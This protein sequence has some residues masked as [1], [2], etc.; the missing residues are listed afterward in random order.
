[1]KHSRIGPALMLAIPIVLSGCIPITF[2]CGGPEYRFASALARITDATDTLHADVYVGAS[3]QRGGGQ[4]T[5]NSFSVNVQAVP[6]Q[7]TVLPLPGLFGH[8]TS[9]RLERADGSVVLRIPL[10]TESNSAGVIGIAVQGITPELFETAR[11]ELLAHHLFVTILVD[12]SVPALGRGAL[13]V[14]ESHDWAK[15]ACQ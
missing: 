3:G 1:M 12:G 6:R 8:A 7:T 11:N 2:D 10:H 4:A 14:V 9:A 15:R 13:A 5:S